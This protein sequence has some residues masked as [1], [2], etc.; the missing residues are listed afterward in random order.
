MVAELE[1]LGLL[2]KIEPHTLSLA[3]CHRCKTLVE[4]LVSTQ[5]FVKMKPLAEPAIEVVDD[6]RI[7]F[8]PENWN[9]TYHHW[10]DN[11]RDWCI[12][13]QLWWGHRIPAWHCEDCKQITVARE[14]SGGMRELRLRVD[15]SR[16]PDVLDTWFSSGLWPFLDAGLA[17]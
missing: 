1:K 17:R 15:S 2:E 5:W 13:R 3:M 8:V 4:P 14:D 10:M 12:S 9:N 7:Q 11:I 16:I 6:G